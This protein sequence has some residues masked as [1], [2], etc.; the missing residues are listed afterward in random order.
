MRKMMING[1]DEYRSGPTKRHKTIR[2]VH[3]RYVDVVADCCVPF[4]VVRVDDE[5]NGCFESWK[6]TVAVVE[7]VEMVVEMVVEYH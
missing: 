3:Y 7:V 5:M 4:V 6:Q 2:V 1:P